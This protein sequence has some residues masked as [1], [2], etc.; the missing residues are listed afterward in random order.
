MDLYF[1]ATGASRHDPA[2]CVVGGIIR[3]LPETEHSV[4]TLGSYE[5]G[6]SYS[7]PRE[8]LAEINIAVGTVV[9][10][11]DSRDIED[12]IRLLHSRARGDS[13][14]YEVRW[15]EIS[16]AWEA[17]ELIRGSDI[18]LRNEVE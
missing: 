6:G 8:A 4:K 1:L 2:A 18:E 5:D 16:R 10:S 11:N 3:G 17:T 13:L 12:I 14:L 7:I 15:N 9:D